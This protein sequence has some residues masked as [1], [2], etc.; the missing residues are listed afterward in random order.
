MIAL[1]F[2]GQGSQKV[3]MGRALAEAFP[4]ARQIFAEADEALGEPLSRLIWEG[5][6]DALM[7]TENTQPAILTASMAA[8]RALESEGLTSRISFVAGHS[9]GEYSANVA[10]GTFSF[11]DAVRAVRRRGRYMQE[12]VPVGT[13]AMSAILGLDVDKVRQACEEAAQGDIVAPANLNG[14]GQVVIAGSRAA[15]ERAGARAKALGAKRVVPLPVSAPF[16]CAL[17][18]PA[19]ERLAPELRALETHTPR[20]P[21]LANVDASP[22]RDAV[23]AIEALVSQISSAVRWEDSVRRLASDGVTA[24]V[25]VG[26]GTVLSG[27]IRKIHRE[28]KVAAVGAPEDF[29]AARALL[30]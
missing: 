18:K 25:E 30:C 4:A 19:A 2:P 15:V 6:E 3:G 16:H 11:T 8:Y 23:S 9:L 12:A 24:Y 28:A 20:V 1:V 17:M 22:K 13:G 26:P 10:A 7:L 21:V 27:L 29:D 5:P 14:A